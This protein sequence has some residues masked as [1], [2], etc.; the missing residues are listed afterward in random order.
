MTDKV[1]HAYSLGSERVEDAIEMVRIAMVLMKMNLKEA[2]IH[3]N[4]NSS[5]P[6]KYDLPMLDEQCFSRKISL[7]LLHHLLA[8]AMAPVTIVELLHN[9]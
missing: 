3:T 9:Q 8:G 7:L 1:C 4:I 5:S 2:R 6:L